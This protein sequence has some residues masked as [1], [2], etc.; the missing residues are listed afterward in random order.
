MDGRRPRAWFQIDLRANAAGSSGAGVKSSSSASPAASNGAR[1]AAKKPF[2]ADWGAALNRQSAAVGQN[3]QTWWTHQQKNAKKWK[4]EMPG[5]PL[6]LRS[7][8]T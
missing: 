1:A 5:Q 6:D 8:I 3:A 7:Q 2:W 4:W